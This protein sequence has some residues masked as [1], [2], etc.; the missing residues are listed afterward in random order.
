[1]HD[2]SYDWLK[3]VEKALLKVQQLPALEEHF[4]FPWDDA[5]KALQETLGLANLNMSCS[6]TVWKNHPEFLQGMGD[7]PSVIALELAPIEGKIFFILSQADITELTGSVLVGGEEKET[8][9][10]AKLKSGFY[11]FLMLKV[12]ATLDHLKIFKDVSLHLLSPSSIPQERG[13]CIDIACQIPSKTL[14]GRLICPQSFLSAFKA[15][16]PLQKT[17]LLSLGHE[18]EMDLT[19]HCEVG[20]TTPMSGTL[21]RWVIS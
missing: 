8:F 16:Q 19:L 1:M 18:T 6:R 11:H 17:T 10:G 2:I 3:L 9:T 21:C 14:Q 13:F 5:G 20:H 4:P 7:T 12:L 15:H